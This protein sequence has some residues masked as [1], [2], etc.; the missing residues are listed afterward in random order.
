MPVALPRLVQIPS[1][2]VS[3]RR[4]GHIRLVVIHDTEGSYEGAVAWF[5]QSRSQVSAHLV[6]SEDGCEVTQMVPL[7]EKAWHACDFNSVSVGIEG[8]GVEARGFSDAWWRGMAAIVGWLLHR[9]GLP[10]RW[11]E[12]GDGE[13]F[14]SHH[15]LGASGGGHNDPCAVGSADWARFLGLVETAYREFAAGPLPEWALHGL[16]A[17]STVSLPSSAPAATTSHGGRPG[18]EP[19]EPHLPAPGSAYPIGSVAD[20]QQR[21]NAA[22]AQPPLTVDGVAGPATMVALEHFQRNLRLAADGVVGPTTWAALE[23]ATA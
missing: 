9:Y 11:A 16:P 2:N 3:S 21:L 5:A 12:A 8:A 13:G 20:I 1:P 14:C 22:G 17:P 23:R 18:V 15:D 4:G 6:M 10:C 7:S 19:A